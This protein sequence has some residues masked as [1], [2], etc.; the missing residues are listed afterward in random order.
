MDEWIGEVRSALANGTMIPPGALAHEELRVYITEQLAAIIQSESVLIPPDSLIVTPSGLRTFIW[1]TPSGLGEAWVITLGPVFTPTGADAEPGDGF[2][3]LF[4]HG[5]H[6]GSRG[7]T[8]SHMDRMFG[9]VLDELFARIQARIN[10][11]C[12]V[13][14]DEEAE[15]EPS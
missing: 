14:P 15:D 11:L 13:V 3:V 2:G 12:G 6:A 9:D 7:G 8:P 1:M 5:S 4:H 10:P